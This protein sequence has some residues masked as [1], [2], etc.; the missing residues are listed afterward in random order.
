M[1]TSATLEESKKE[2][3]N[4]KL[5][6]GPT[7]RFRATNTRGAAFYGMGAFVDIGKPQRAHVYTAACVPVDPDAYKK[8]DPKKLA[9]KTRSRQVHG[10]QR[11]LLDDGRT[12]L[13]RRRHRQLSWGQDEFGRRHDR[14][15]ND[16]QFPD[17]LPAVL[18]QARHLWTCHAGKPVH[19]FREPNGPVWVL[20]EYT[21]AVDPSLTA[22]NLDTVGSKL[23]PCPRL[24]V[25]TK[26]LAKNLTLDTG[27]AGGWAAIM[28]DDLH[29]T[30]QGCGYGKDTSANY[31]P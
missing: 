28:R 12:R 10:Q 3:Q 7:R 13:R 24:D 25:E 14:G 5:K 1:T 27:R 22:D 17:R 26:V 16:D 30:Y 20:Q 6:P 21:K 29:C 8:I 31:V 15:R 19:L 18:D 9:R 23:R 4:M 2:I 11:P